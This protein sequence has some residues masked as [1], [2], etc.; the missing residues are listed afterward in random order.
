MP[1]TL[2]FLG[3]AG[4]VTGSKYLLS[5]GTH[6]LLIDC[7]MFQGERSWR[8]KNWL[9]P[10][11]DLRSIDAVLLTHAHIDHTGILPRC[12]ALGLKAPVWCSPA[13]AELTQLLLIDSGRLQEEEAEFRT[14]H[15]RSR[16][17][18]PLPLYTEE[19]A[20]S[21]VSLLKP[22][23]I[24][25]PTSILPGISAQWSLMGHI[26]GACSIS[27]TIAGKKIVFS[28][29]I[30]RYDQPILVDPTPAELGDLL[31]IESTYG[32]RTH[33]P[34][35][36]P[37]EQLAEIISRTASRGGVVVIPSFAVGRTQTILYYLRELKAAKRI[38]DIP[39]IIDSP[40]AHDATS[41]YQH[42]T[43]EY[44]AAALALLKKG[45]QPFQVPK[46]YFTRE[47]AESIKLNSIHEPM[48]IIS[49]S[50]MLSG[51]RILHH[52]KHRVSNERNTILF[53][54][55]QPPGSRGDW[56]KRGN[57]TMTLLGEEI[58][59]RAEVCE[60]SGLSAH[61]DRDEL[62]RWCRS[63]TGTPGRVAVVHGEPD[64]ASAFSK[65]LKK[66]LG[67]N[68]FVPGYGETITI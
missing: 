43:N 26:V 7:G 46:M 1:I 5:D 13:T 58:P 36:D 62:L 49:A 59:V 17:T 47:R 65:T 45:F 35:N 40:M 34:E 31:L 29:D 56:L 19:Q 57:K 42:H 2:R 22:T 20:K 55:F 63:C 33:H 15:K 48:I 28:G 52:L 27:L 32:D 61:G 16:H 8:E 30:G 3:A 44:D 14:S 67:W 18:P 51:G 9:A 60:M 12:H 39:I 6:S 54:G 10:D 68:A 38:P 53:V 4:T 11:F 24:N 21:A 41:I 23:P 50:G 66:E 37:H 64:S 25:T